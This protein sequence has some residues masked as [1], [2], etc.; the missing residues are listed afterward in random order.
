MP[1]Y[2]FN[3]RDGRAGIPDVEG[4]ELSDVAA[5]RSHAVEVARELMKRKEVA[6]RPWR[7]DVCDDRGHLAFTIPFA[8]VDTTLDHLAPDLR[9]LVERV[10][11]SK[12]RLSETIFRSESL[13]L[14]MRAAQARRIR[15]PYVVTHL[16][17]R[18]DAPLEEWRW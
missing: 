10:S 6:K 12:R 11:E 17:R 1:V 2:H 4:T 14:G 13:A 3:L 16:G 15:K 9:R 7:L 8:A 18:V 5:A